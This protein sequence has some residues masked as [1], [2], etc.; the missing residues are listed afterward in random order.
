MI[1]DKQKAR[2]IFMKGLR[3]YLTPFAPDQSG[4]VSM[5][6]ALE[7]MVVIVDAGGCA[8]NICGFDEPRWQPDYGKDSRVGAVF[9]AGLRDMDAILGRDEALVSKL[10]E[11]AGE[12]NAAFIALVGTPVP[13]VIGTDLSAVARMAQR[14]TGLPCIAIE[15]DG[16]HLYDQGIEDALLALVKTLPSLE[17]GKGNAVSEAG[18]GNAAA[19]TEAGNAVS[20]ADNAVSEVKAGNAAAKAG[21]GNAAAKPETDDNASCGSLHKPGGRICGVLGLTPLDLFDPQ[22]M[23]AIR[24]ALLAQGYDD[25]LMPGIEDGTDAFF[26]MR[27]AEQNYVV[28]PAGIAAAKYLEQA[29]GTPYVVT[30]PADPGILLEEDPREALSL[31]RP[32]A[33][34]LVVHQQ[35]LANAIRRMLRESGTSGTINTATW[36]MKRT[37]LSEDGDIRLLEEDDFTVLVRDGGYDLIIADPALRPMAK[38]YHGRWIDAFH[39]AVSGQAAIDHRR[40]AIG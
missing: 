1:L 28:S 14:A 18:T 22:W 39:F 35:V 21:A 20:K 10:V 34:I 24:E 32:D 26:R 8:G 31:L 3:K 11:A 17:A 16:M 19:K 38:G 29:F 33:R 4:A 23:D 30:F 27:Q 13:A 37:D 12:V 40:M 25:V 7:G 9:S 5:C 36:F 2:G 6:Y 15:T